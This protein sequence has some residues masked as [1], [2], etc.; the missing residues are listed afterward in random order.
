MLVKIVY[1]AHV[2]GAR[3]SRPGFRSDLAK[4]A[5]LLVLRYENAVLRRHPG[6]V[7]YEPTDRAW[8][9][10]LARLIPRRRWPKPAETLHEAEPV[11]V[12]REPLTTRSEAFRPADRA[13]R[14]LHNT[15]I[16]R[17][18]HPVVGDPVLSF[19][20]MKTFRRRSCRARTPM[21][22][23]ASIRGAAPEASMISS[24]AA[25]GI[26]AGRPRAV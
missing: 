2:P 4:D 6:R 11:R 7:R 24:N 16:K 1:P 12:G 18:H 8:F 22:S 3:P 26:I 21:G 19:E 5:E 25:S 9:I 15:E 14:R 13:Q 10:A 17:F 23:M 20:T